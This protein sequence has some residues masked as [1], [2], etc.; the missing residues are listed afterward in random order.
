MHVMVGISVSRKGNSMKNS[1]FR[2]A[3]IVYCAPLLFFVEAG[4]AQIET[5]TRTKVKSVSFSTIAERKS[6]RIECDIGETLVSAGVKP[7]EHVVVQSGTKLNL[8]DFEGRAARVFIQRVPTAAEISLMAG[9]GNVSELTSK[10]DFL[11]NV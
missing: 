10:S 5:I 3:K 9:G 6:R 4:I 8:Q 1:I 7:V 11:L 2:L